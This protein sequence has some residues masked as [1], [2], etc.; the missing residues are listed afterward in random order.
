M[1]TGI[2]TFSLCIKSSYSDIK[3]ILQKNEYITM[4][5]DKYLL[6]KLHCIIKYK[7]YGVEILLNQSYNRP[8]FI[9]VIVNPSSLLAYEYRP[10]D[11][12]KVDSK[13]TV[14]LL[15]Q[16]LYSI[17]KEIGINIK[18]ANISLLRCDL[19]KDMYLPNYADI[20]FMLKVFQK[21]YVTD[22]RLKVDIKKHSWTIKNKSREFCVYNKTYELKKRH[23]VDISDNI[24]RLELRLSPKSMP[25]KYKSKSWT[26][27]LFKLYADH[28]KLINSFICKI[29]QDF[30]RVVSYDEAIQIIDGSKYRKKTKHQLKKIIK[31]AST[32][33]SLADARKKCE[34]RK[35]KFIK[36]L[37]KFSEMGICAITK[38]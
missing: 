3:N 16:K 17:L 12:F 33:N 8:S 4:N 22:K 19:T 20:P 9:T 37:D 35:D 15:K 30:E 11:L 24:L 23:E 5:K 31:K 25:K 29:H 10:T 1:N 36:L 18:K 26:D 38:D 13:K 21:S 32:C 2:H 28:N 34:I 6:N 27:E 14:K 7:K